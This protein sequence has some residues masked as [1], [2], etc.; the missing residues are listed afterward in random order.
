MPEPKQPSTIQFSTVWTIDLIAFNNIMSRQQPCSQHGCTC[1]LP[2]RQNESTTSQALPFNS[3][4]L[5]R[6][7]KLTIIIATLAILLS[8]TS[9]FDYYGPSASIL[10][11]IF[12]LICSVLICIID[13]VWYAQKKALNPDE[14]PHWPSKKFMLAD[15]LLA[16]SLFVAFW[17]F[18]GD[19]QSGCYYDY[20]PR[21]LQAYGAL[22]V[23]M[24][25]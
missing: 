21:L 15:L 20:A 16:I 25:S 6:L 2:P 8:S 7:R 3:H 9:T 10:F 19:L 1:A 17:G 4:P 23:V 22:G 24:C 18:V 12:L 13:L 11:S 5:F 14:G